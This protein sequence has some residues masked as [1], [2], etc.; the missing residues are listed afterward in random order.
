[1]DYKYNYDSDKDEFNRTNLA[2]FWIRMIMHSTQRTWFKGE[3]VKFVISQ[4]KQKNPNSDK[5]EVDAHVHSQLQTNDI[6]GRNVEWYAKL[7][8]MRKNL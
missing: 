2:S 6:F 4:Y 5:V 7:F 8:Y 3:A 1:V